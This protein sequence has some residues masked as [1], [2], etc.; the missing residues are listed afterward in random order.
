MR[1]FLFAAFAITSALLDGCSRRSSAPRTYRN[2]PVI[3][4]SI[5]TVRA[6]HLPMF[7]YRGV[8]T[9]HLDALRRDGVLFTSAYSHVPLTLPSHTSI[10]TGLLPQHNGVRNNLGYVLDAKT[11]TIASFLKQQGY[12]TGAAVS[13]FV[14]RG[15]AGL[16]HSFDF[17]DD[18][19]ANRPGIP[20]GSLQRSGRVTEEIANRWIGQREAKP[21]FFFF[22][23]FE[24]HSPYEP[25]EPF[26]SR[27]ANAY[28]GE[29]ATADAIVGD[30]IETLKRRGIYDRA[31]IVMLSDHGEGLDQHGEPEHG[32][33][34]YREDI[35][36]PLVVK[37]PGNARSD[38]TLSAPVGLIDV[39]PTI[40]QL[41][42]ASP[43]AHLDGR[44][45]F[46]QEDNTRHI[47][48]ESL[49]ARIHLGWSEL[50]SLV[51]TQKHF[52]E[53]PKP[54]LYDMQ[55]DPS[56]TKNIV[57]DDRRAYAQMRDELARYKDNAALPAHIDPEEAKKLAALGYL[58]ATPAPASGDLP[59]P[60]D[61][62]GEI[63]EMMQATR[64]LNEH[65]NEEAILAF[66]RIVAGNPR[67]TDAWNELGTALEAAGRNEEASEIY[68]KAIA[69]TPELAGEF[70]LRRAAVL[71]RLEQYD[72]AER[73]ARLGQ[74][75]N[76]GGTHLML[77]R[78]A[79]TRKNFAQAEQEARIAMGDANN[80]V[81]AEVLLAQVLA[82]QGRV[83]EAM[84][85]IDQAGKEIQQEKL[86]E[87]ESY[88]FARGDVLARMT[89]YDEAIAEFKQEIAQFPQNRQPYANL[90][91]V[92][93]VRN[94][95][96]SAQ[97]T[98]DDMVR[99]IPGKAT[100]LFAAKTVGALGDARGAAEWKK[101]AAQMR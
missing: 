12:D 75:S 23:I 61:R 49:Y 33:F 74:R 44:S 2:A 69:T 71:L 39:F 94:D 98:I 8:D 80:R 51:D 31:V 6:D 22:H 16:A 57:S 25:E 77:S 36:V 47:Y 38:S 32:I 91:L 42:G 34:I 65:K 68:K 58:S 52:I 66:R 35:H 3:I 27:V 41:V 70:G 48:S 54:E 29:I 85:V 64:L 92:Y 96:A 18:T 37:L 4:I 5:D 46:A 86:G 55:R 95:P 19:I 20:A 11:V 67:L 56:E 79:L 84:P 59:D 87:I 13:A 7:G 100:L 62:I 90:H 76:L 17:Y 97:R 89:R 14:L 21:F 60:K 88:H 82:Q 73:H 81:A 9:P 101:R 99:T 78:I 72:E 50:R 1:R 93:R 15:S 30:F 26:R 43:P 45:L 28:D 10:L 63:A 83:R 24:P 53:A 40:A